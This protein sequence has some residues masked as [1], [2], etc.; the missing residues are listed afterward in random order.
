[1]AEQAQPAS[2]ET[3]KDALIAVMEELAGILDPVGDEGPLPAAVR[4]ALAGPLHRAR[5]LAAALDA[6]AGPSSAYQLTLDAIEQR[7]TN[8]S[9]ASSA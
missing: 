9:A 5:E 4:Q 7:I 6:E 8:S 3:T 1:M 2:P